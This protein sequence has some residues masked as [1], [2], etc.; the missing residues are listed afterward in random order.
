MLDR[1]VCGRMRLEAL[2]AVSGEALRE[3]QML[4]GQTRPQ[5]AERLLQAR[6]HSLRVEETADATFTNTTESPAIRPVS[7]FPA[8]SGLP[9]VTAGGE[10]GDGAIARPPAA[11]PSGPTPGGRARS[12]GER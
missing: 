8:R 9:G 10:T 1:A 2:P 11:S 4:L 7:A 5:A 6:H 12:G 3:L